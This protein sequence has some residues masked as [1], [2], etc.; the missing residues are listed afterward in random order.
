MLLVLSSLYGIITCLFNSDF[1][2][3]QNNLSNTAMAMASYESG[4]YGYIAPI[5]LI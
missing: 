5:E 4:T 1:P 2:E 3:L